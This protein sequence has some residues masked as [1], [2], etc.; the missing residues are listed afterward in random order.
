MGKE[1]ITAANNG[2]IRLLICYTKPTDLLSRSNS[3]LK[4][5]IIEMLKSICRYF[6]ICCLIN[7]E[8]VSLFLEGSSGEKKQ[9]N[10]VNDLVEFLAITSIYEKNNPKLSSFYSSVFELLTTFML[11][12]DDKSVADKC[13]FKI[14]R[15]WNVLST[16]LVDEI[17]EIETEFSSENNE[18]LNVGLKFFAAYFARLTQ[19]ISPSSTTPNIEI[20][21]ENVSLLFDSAS[22]SS[23][24]FGTRL[25]RK[26]IKFFD[27]YFLVDSNS[28]MKVFI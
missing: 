16:Y 1:A 9:I 26:L 6:N 18:L 3:I 7:P 17:L 19:L 20:V 23:E 21:R 24:S 28:N 5:N 8:C 12:S 11:T 15:F 4:S 27:K 14:T 25:C 2:I 10:L 13:I 22:P